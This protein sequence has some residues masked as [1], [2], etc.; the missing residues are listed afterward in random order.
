MLRRLWEVWEWSVVGCSELQPCRG[1]GGSANRGG[2]TPGLARGLLPLLRRGRTRRR[3]GGV[4]RGFTLGLSTQTVGKLIRTEA[5][6]L[7]RTGTVTAG[8][9]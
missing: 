2:P 4:A 3:G 8:A 1:T 7:R 6:P 9:E 5:S